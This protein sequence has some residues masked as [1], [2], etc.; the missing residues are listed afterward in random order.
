MPSRSMVAHLRMAASCRTIDSKMSRSASSPTFD[1]GFEFRQEVLDDRHVESSEVSPFHVAICAYRKL[2]ER[3]I[4]HLAKGH[5]VL[6]EQRAQSGL[7]LRLQLQQGAQVITIPRGFCLLDKGEKQRLSE[8]L[9]LIELTRARGVRQILHGGPLSFVWWA[10]KSNS[11]ADRCPSARATSGTSRRSARATGL[12]NSSIS[13][14]SGGS[15]TVAH[16]SKWA[17]R[18]GGGRPLARRGATFRTLHQLV[19]GRM[20]GSGVRPPPPDLV[21][22]T[23]FSSR[24]T[25]AQCPHSKMTL[26][27]PGEE[28]LGKTPQLTFETRRGTL[29]PTDRRP[30]QSPI[31]PCPSRMAGIPAARRRPVSICPRPEVHR[32]ARAASMTSTIFPAPH[33]SHAL[34][35]SC[36]PGA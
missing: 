18:D 34:L 10:T 30:G 16:F 26:W 1:D 17:S 24:S 8:D 5:A 7:R 4:R 2:D 6:E 23:R 33:L 15:K 14:S 29:R 3:E 9:A 32:S 36:A 13:S 35:R 21:P 12:S 11:S 31:R 25:R 27:L 20:R 28:L 22:L 19:Q